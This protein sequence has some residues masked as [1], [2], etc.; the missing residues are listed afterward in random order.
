MDKDKQLISIEGSRALVR[1][2]AQMGLVSKVVKEDESLFL[3]SKTVV[4][5]CI[6]WKCEEVVFEVDRYKTSLDLSEKGLVHLSSEIGQLK[7]LKKL[8]LWLNFK[9]I[10]LPI[11][12]WQLSN[13]THLNLSSNQLTEI[14]IEIGQLTNLTHLH[15][16]NNQLK[17]IPIEIG[18]LANLKEL[19]LFNNQLTQIPIE[20]EQL[21]NLTTLYLWDNP[22]SDLEKEKIRL[23]LPNCKIRFEK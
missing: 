22:I 1:I 12:I 3:Q 6:N 4:L 13:L 20:I 9:L 15:L 17:E 14:P 5:R 16:F 19:W 7:S 18:Q 2:G 8:N 23:L 10:E 21:L 11:E